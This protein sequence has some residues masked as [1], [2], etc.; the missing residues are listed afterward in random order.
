MKKGVAIDSFVDLSVGDYV[1]HE[2]NGIGIYQGIV[3][4][5]TDGINRDFIYIA[6]QGGDK[7]YVPVEQLDVVQ[8]YIGGGEEHTPKVNRLGSREW[9]N[10]KARVK[11]SIR[12]MT[13]ELTALYKQRETVQGYAFGA[14]TPWQRQ[15][16]D[17][18]PYEETPDQLTC[19]DEIKADM[20]RPRVMGSPA[21]RR[22]GIRKN[23]GRAACGVQ[24][25]DGRK[26]GGAA[27]AD[28]DPCSAAL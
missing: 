12:D 27:C 17:D 21:V 18:F 13:E 28:Y 7:L 6:Y 11:K 5:Q 4:I 24:S 3:K 22:C 25:G 19:I 14:D 8:K 20:E 1:V 2:T 15:F 10:T 26:A 23:R 16:E 9:Q